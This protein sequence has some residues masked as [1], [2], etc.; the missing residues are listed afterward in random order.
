[1]ERDFLN[2]NPTKKKIPPGKPEGIDPKIS[3]Y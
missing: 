3:S 2:Q 1:M